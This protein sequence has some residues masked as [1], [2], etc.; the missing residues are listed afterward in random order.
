MSPSLPRP[1]AV[2]MGPQRLAPIVDHALDLL[3]LAVTDKVA[4]IT[5]GWQER[6]REDDELQAAL[7]GRPAENLL[8][9]ERGD[10]VYRDDPELFI[11]HRARQDKLKRLQELY[12]R[13]L[14]HAM[15]AALEMQ[16]LLDREHSDEDG[17]IP[18]ELVQPQLAN[19]IA[20]VQKLDDEHEQMTSAVNETFKAT[21]EPRKRSAVL[22]QR[23]ELDEILNNCRAVAIAG[24]H[25]AVLLNKL[26]LF[27]LVDRL[28]EKPIVAWSA[29]AMVLTDR[30]VLY[31]DTPPQGRGF[32]EVLG[33]GLGLMPDVV[34]LPHAR[35]RLLV[36]NRQR[37][38]LLARRL[39]PQNCVAL[40]ERC[41]LSYFEGNLGRGMWRANDKT[42]RLDV[43]GSCRPMEVS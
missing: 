3:D 19:A 1:S 29:G 21:H 11:Q 18:R 25:V 8:L 9:H 42:R 13:R 30:I 2:F 16:E 24:G 10:A 43:D 15:A 33:A 27:G 35:K 34:V 26:E 32:A 4:I 22:R 31:H 23:Q 6:E 20:A 40:D 17:A 41:Y 36:D 7:G 12:R 14:T 38:S 28:A 39:S 5:A 37:I